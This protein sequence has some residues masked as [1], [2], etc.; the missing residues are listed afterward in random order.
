M[1]AVIRAH[2]CRKY[3][4]TGIF[5]SPN[6]FH[7][8]S[9]VYKPTNAV[10]N[11][12]TSLTPVTHPSETPVYM[13]QNHHQK[14]NGCF[15]I[16][17]NRTRPR[18][19]LTVNTRSIESSKINLEIVSSPLSSKII[20][21]NKCLLRQFQLSDCAV[22]YAMGTMAMPYSDMIIRILTNGTCLGY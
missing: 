14:V 3:V 1:R 8:S 19:V 10:T 17:W 20:I 15:C 11:K 4:R 16:R 18:T 12:P 2:Q 6:L 7:K 22:M 9:M 21:A 13:S 5:R